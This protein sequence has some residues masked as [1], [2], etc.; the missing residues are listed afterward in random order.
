MRE[1]VLFEALGYVDDAYLDM[2][3]AL[4]KEDLNMN[5]SAKHT[6]QRKTLSVILAA[7]ICA[8]ILAVTA[9]ATGL[10]PKIFASVDSANPEEQ[11]ILD[12]AIE[13]TQ[14][15]EPEM[16]QIPEV[17][18]TQITLFERYYDGESILL[19]Y[20]LT[21][22]MPEPIVGVQPGPALLEKIKSQ[23]QYQAT[24]YPGLTDDTL[25]GRLSLGT[26]T[27]EEYEHILDSRSEYAKRYD[28]RKS[29]QITMDEH[30]Q[31]YLTPEQY[32]QFW[33]ILG[34][35]GVCCVAI[36]ERPWIGDHILANGTD[37]FTLLGP[38]CS[39]FRYDYTTEVGECIL[40][41]PL[42]ECAVNQ[43]SVTV[44]LE[45]HSGWNY[46]YMELDGDV[47]VRFDTNPVHTASFT[48]ENVNY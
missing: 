26:L 23:P 14:T 1:N 21:K 2:V 19:G 25:E 36:P 20:N 6:I 47:Y 5:P 42:P 45:L 27:Q 34:Q 30:M 33:Q 17:D 16:V 37:F 13:A 31:H 32:E 35:T 24:P 22:L 38:E 28:L 10:I 9:A 8:S 40:L 3:D 29:W 15:Q 7:A 12:A 18:F 41:K 46:W 4:Q 39:N 11:K 48:L 44:E 43:P